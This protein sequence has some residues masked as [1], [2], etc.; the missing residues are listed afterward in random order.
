MD[1][2]LS[3]GVSPDRAQSGRQYKKSYRDCLT[4]LLP[5]VAGRCGKPV[6]RL[7]V[8][9]LSVDRVTAILAHLEQERGCSVQTRNQRLLEPALQTLHPAWIHRT[10]GTGRSPCAGTR[11]VKDHAARIAARLRLPHASLRRRYRHHSGLARSRVARN[12]QHLRRNRSQGEGRGDE[13][14]LPR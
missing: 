13:I 9:D 1:Q 5:L 7:K 8:E 2:A 12:H 6:E 10:G 4:L 11:R 14:H 3:H